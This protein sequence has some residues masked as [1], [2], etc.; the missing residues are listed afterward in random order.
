MRRPHESSRTRQNTCQTSSVQSGP[1]PPLRLCRQLNFHDTMERA[2]TKST[3]LLRKRHTLGLSPIEQKRAQCD[4][5][6]VV[7]ALT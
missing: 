3:R 7:A 5:L 6:A 1:V 2:T 4:L